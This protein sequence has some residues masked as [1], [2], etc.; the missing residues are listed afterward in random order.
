M[1]CHTNMPYLMARPA[2]R[3]ELKSSGEVRTF[4]E[5]YYLERWDKGKKSPEKNYNPVVVAT[6]L[7]FNDI[8]YK[9]VLSEVTSKTL[10][11]MWTTQRLDGSWDWAKCGWA[12]MEIDDHFGVTLAAITVG[13]APSNY[14]ST[15]KAQKGLEKIRSYLKERPSPSLHHRV[16]KAWASKRVDGIMSHED[17][18]KV[19]NEISSRQL[20]DG[21][22]ST[23]GFL[24]DWQEYK[25]IDRKPL[26]AFTSDGYGTGLAIIVARELGKPVKDPQIQRGIKWIKENQRKNGMWFTRSPA[27]DSKHFITNTGT[28]FVVLALQSCH[29]LPGWPF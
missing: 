25:R 18:Q 21:G 7:V 14:K 17:I 9:G 3:N 29:E 27:K 16:M 11:M 5:N 23:S 10:D 20:P 26:D 13:M 12:P 1:T 6:G 2:L 4:F 24:M 8:Q 19:L 22:W 28:A 15:P